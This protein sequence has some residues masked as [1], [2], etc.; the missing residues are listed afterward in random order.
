MK[1]RHQKQMLTFLQRLTGNIVAM[2]FCL[3]QR[4]DDLISYSHSGLGSLHFSVGAGPG[5]C[6][7]IIGDESLDPFGTTA[8]QIGTP[9][10]LRLLK[11]VVFYICKSMACASVLVERWL[12][13]GKCSFFQKKLWG[14]HSSL[15]QLLNPTG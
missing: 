4:E 3:T 7:D 8:L 12:N 1:Q 6:S 13:F 2:A 15:R 14:K 11:E 9:N 10:S 5:T